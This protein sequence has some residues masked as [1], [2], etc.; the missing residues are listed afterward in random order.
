MHYRRWR[1]YGDP[2]YVQIVMSPKSE[3]GLC[4]YSGCSQPYAARGYCDKHYQRWKKHGSPD[5]IGRIGSVPGVAR[6]H[7]LAMGDSYLYYHVWSNMIDRCENPDHPAYHN[8]GGR[9]IY[10]CDRWKEDVRNFVADMGTRPERMT[11]DRINNDGPYSPENCR[12]ATWSQ[13][14][15]NKRPRERDDYGRFV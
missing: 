1:L 8:Y 6:K 7:G 5:V 2:H 11:L 12:W 14:A 10:V 3:T 15:R 4:S 9:G 13:Q